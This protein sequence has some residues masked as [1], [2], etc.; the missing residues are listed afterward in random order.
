MLV[1]AL[2]GS[3]DIAQS[4][5]SQRATTLRKAAGLPADDYY[6]IHRLG[7]PSLLHSEKRASLIELRD[8]YQEIQRQTDL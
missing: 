1:K 2:T 8:R 3:F 6:R 7:D 4:S 5:V